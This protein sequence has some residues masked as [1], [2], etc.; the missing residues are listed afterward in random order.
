MGVSE[1]S[2][3]QGWDP[4]GS[5]GGAG[6]RVRI[7]CAAGFWGD[8]E[9]AAPQLL[10]GGR[11]DYLVFDYLAEI[12]MSI[13][14][15]ARLARADGG[16]AHDF[17]SR[18][19]APCLPELMKQGVKV[20][21]NA[22]GVNP[23][24]CRAALEAVAARLGLSPKIAVVLGDDLMP[25]KAELLAAGTR[26]MFS[27]EAF[28]AAAISI[29]AYLG[30]SPIARALALGADIVITGRVVDSALVLGPLL[31]EHG[32]QLDAW[33]KLAQGS[34]AGH[35][36]ECGA[37][38]TGG[39]FT[40]WEQVADG[41]E[42]MGFPIVEVAADGSFVVEKPAGTGGVVSPQVVLE[43][44]VYEIGD[45]RAYLLPDVSCDFTQVRAEALG[46]DRV[47]VLGARGRPPPARYKVSATFPDGFKTT[48]GFLVAGEQ[49]VQKGE[50]VGRALLAKTR[51]LL[52]ERGLGDFRDSRVDV[53]G[54]EASYGPHARAAQV[55]EVVVRVA[56]SHA[57]DEAL[58]LMLR[59]LPQAGT[60]MV[61]GFCTGIGGRSGAMPMVRLF[62]FLTDPAAL[63]VCVDFAGATHAVPITTAEHFD[64]ASLPEEQSTARPVPAACTRTVPLIALAHGRSGDKGNHSNIGILAR[65]PEYLPYI[66]AAL[67]TD[68]V[69]AYMAHLLDPETGR[70][71]RWALPGCHGFNFLLENSLGGG[72]IASLRPDPQGKA[73]AQQLL[74]F[75]VPVPEALHAQLGGVS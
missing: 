49:A 25:R 13:M 73:Y 35:I 26:E 64:P 14:A 15:G 1:A 7:G 46:S 67:S 19:M 65:A 44:L 41:Y 74:A 50:R 30:A 43:Q 33:D 21:S 38:A 62:S 29:N 6:K 27:G 51:K 5:A 75:P 68:A 22:G 3:A 34:L 32:W 58:K 71:R 9:S 10:K 17:V 36:V 24:A 20:V 60:G 61:P 2:P 28:P 47:R 70:V 52:L 8:T 11:L 53:L 45:P 63:Q 57:S 39:I 23:L 69:A 66:D 4:D 18:V 55:R 54:S 42:D 72:G 12:T 59:E 37:Q 40:D 31:H 48:A 16:H 56:A